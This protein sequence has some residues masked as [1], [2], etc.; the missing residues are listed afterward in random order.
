MFVAAS[1]LP[2]PTNR[3]FAEDPVDTLL[4]KGQIIDRYGPLDGRY[5]SIPGQSISERGMAQGSEGM[6]YT[7]L[8]VLK[9]L[10]VPGGT[11]APVPEFGG[12]GGAPQYFFQGGIQSWIDKGFLR[13]VK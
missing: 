13:E 3:G 11:V 4:S 5:A 12:I 7:K 2:W 8:E 1:D 6:K 9:P 10:T